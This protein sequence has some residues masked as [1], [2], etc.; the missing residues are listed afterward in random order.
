MWL[1]VLLIP[2]QLPRELSNILFKHCPWGSTYIPSVNIFLPN[3]QKNWHSIWNKHRQIKK[4]SRHLI[5]IHLMQLHRSFI[6]SGIGLRFLSAFFP[7]NYSPYS[8]ITLSQSIDSIMNKKKTHLHGS[9]R[10]ELHE[11]SYFFFL[12]TLFLFHGKH[13]VQATLGKMYIWFCMTIHHIHRQ[14]CSGNLTID[15]SLFEIQQI[16]RNVHLPQANVNRD[17]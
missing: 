17:Q 9:K 11:C 13:H 4:K 14:S 2:E 6:I 3:P 10:H 16:I 8:K 7:I 12:F 15:Y 1:A 5:C